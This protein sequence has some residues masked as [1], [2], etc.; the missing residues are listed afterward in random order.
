MLHYITDAECEY[1][2]TKK[3]EVFLNYYYTTDIPLTC[4]SSSQK[5][6]TGYL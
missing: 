1:V 5:S 6:L 3:R 4:L 2:T